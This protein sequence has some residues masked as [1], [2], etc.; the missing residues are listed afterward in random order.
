MRV[1]TRAEILTIDAGK[2]GNQ[3]DIAIKNEKES[4]AVLSKGRIVSY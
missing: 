4:D 2:E 1:Q 3:K